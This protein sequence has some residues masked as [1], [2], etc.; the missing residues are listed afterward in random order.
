MGQFLEGGPYGCSS[1]CCGSDY[2]AYPPLLCVMWSLYTVLLLTS[3]CLI[4]TCR[5]QNAGKTCKLKHKGKSFDVQEG[6]VTYITKNTVKVC[7]NGK[8]TYVNKSEVR[9][10]YKMGCGGCWYGKRLCNGDIVQDLHRW[11]FLNQC[12]NGRMRPVG[13]SYEEVSRDPRF[14]L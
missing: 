8:L 4:S 12:S 13:R 7:K 3:V 6:E 1:W 2:P 11:W 5:G 9:A 10:P 14:K